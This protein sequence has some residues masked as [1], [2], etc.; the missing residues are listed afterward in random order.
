MG[1]FT[2]KE[3]T[4]T[5]Q[6]KPYTEIKVVDDYGEYT[7]RINE[8]DLELHEMYEKLIRPVLLAQGYSKESIEEYFGGE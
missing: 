8:I 1:D 7:I 6:H 4:K 3:E 2:Y 5:T